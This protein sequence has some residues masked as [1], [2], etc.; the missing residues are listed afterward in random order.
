MGKDG[1]AQDADYHRSSMDGSPADTLV[2]AAAV[3]VAAERRGNHGRAMMAGRLR[4]SSA[5]SADRPNQRRRGPS[6]ITTRIP[7]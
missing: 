7:S 4:V 6:I 1:E 3:R 2:G 5:T